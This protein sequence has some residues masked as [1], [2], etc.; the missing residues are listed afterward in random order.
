MLKILKKVFLKKCMVCLLELISRLN[1]YFSVLIYWLISG[2]RYIYFILWV[3]IQ[4]HAT[5]LPWWIS[6]RIHLQCAGNPS[7]IPGLGRSP[8]EGNGNPLQY[9]CLE[10]SRDTRAWQAIVHEVTRGRHDLMTKPPSP[11]CTNSVAQIVCWELIQVCSSC[12]LHLF[13]FFSTSLHSNNTV[14]PGFSFSASVLESDTSP[15]NPVFF[16]H[17]DGI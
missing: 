5:G 14:S 17:G 12:V 6:Q 13:W 7:S 4:Y 1:F 10:K 16:L 2:T 11:H 15:R 8:G 3:I 9:Y